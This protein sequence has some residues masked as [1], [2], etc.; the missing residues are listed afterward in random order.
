MKRKLFLI[1][2]FMVVATVTT[3]LPLQSSLTYTYQWEASALEDNDGMPLA[4]VDHYEVWIEVNQDDPVQVATVEDGTTYTLTAEPGSSYRVRVCAIDTLGRCSDP[5]EWSD[6][7]VI[8]RTTDVPD[9]TVADLAPAYPNPFN[10]STTLRYAV[11]TDLAA[12]APVRLRIH[13]ARG[14]LVRELDVDRSAGWHTVQWQ[15]RDRRGQSVA[16]GTYLALYT[17]GDTQTVTRL[18]LLK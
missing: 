7:L 15:G 16:S 1:N 10:P 18:T 12:G 14:A 4:P 13:D 5:S 2:A 9:V 17:C 8:P 6:P 11:P 3:A